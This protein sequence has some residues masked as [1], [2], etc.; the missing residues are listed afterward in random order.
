MIL[1]VDD[2]SGFLFIKNISAVVGKIVEYIYKKSVIVV[3][4]IVKSRVE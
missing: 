1:F 2:N 4:L 3:N